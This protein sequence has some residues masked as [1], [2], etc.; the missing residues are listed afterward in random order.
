M[1]VSYGV[2]AGDSWVEHR[3][4]TGY[5][6]T[7]NVLTWAGGLNGNTWDKRRNDRQLSKWRQC[8]DV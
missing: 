6:G 5:I 7:T 2:P 8:I 4:I 3:T 1:G